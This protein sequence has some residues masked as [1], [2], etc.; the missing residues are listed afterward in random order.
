MA[1]TNKYVIFNF[2]E[3]SFQVELADFGGRRGG[4][5][6]RYSIFVHA[7]TEGAA[8]VITRGMKGIRKQILPNDHDI[9][10]AEGDLWS[11]IQA[12]RFG[13][14]AQIPLEEGIAKTVDWF[15]QEHA[16]SNIAG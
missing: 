1:Y 14:S 6:Y 16:L 3:S 4:Q 2:E 5:P 7:R 12:R 9:V 15:E 10:D 11:I 13:F 8:D